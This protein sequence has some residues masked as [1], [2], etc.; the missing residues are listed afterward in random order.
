MAETT[1]ATDLAERQALGVVIER[2][3]LAAQLFARVAVADFTGS[4]LMV[5]EA[6]HALRIARSAFDLTLIGAEMTR[7]GTLGRAGGLAYL[8]QLIAEFPNHTL[9][10]AYTDEIAHAVRRRRVWAI[11]TRTV[12]LAASPEQDPVALARRAVGELTAVVDIAATDTETVVPTLDE[13][14]ATD[15]APYDWAVRGLVERSDRAIITGEEG[16]GK[17]VL[18]RQI[19]VCGSAG[20]HPFTLK[21]IP[22][23]DVLVIDCENTPTQSRR[24][25]RALATAA[26]AYGAPG[27][28]GRLRIECRPEG[29][30]LTRAGDEGWLVRT[31][32]TLQPAILVIGPV[33][34]LHAGNPNDEEPARAV[35]RVLDRC[36]S[37]AN[38]AVIVEG[39][40]P[41]ADLKGGVRNVRPIGSSLWLRWPEFGYGLVRQTD[42]GGNVAYDPF[43]RK[44]DFKPWRGDRSGD[45]HWPRELHAGGL[46][47]WS[48]PGL[49]VDPPPP[50]QSALQI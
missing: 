6:I 13:F 38:C 22:P 1:R 37:A 19:A 45:R 32:T 9:L 48:T 39:H 33:Y 36:R 31:V 14:L 3:D 8:H 15:D 12:A 10:E 42:T 43:N 47:P 20:L 23:V 5:A 4:N 17:S 2:P 21:H 18:I 24:E 16:L 28:G 35:A 41:H 40:S 49:L 30:D 46:M 29:L 7:R 34:R 27:M 50:P 25:Y 26:R 44:V 11:A